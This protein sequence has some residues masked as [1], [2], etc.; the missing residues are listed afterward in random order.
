M[1][2]EHRLPIH[3]RPLSDR[4]LAASARIKEFELAIDGITAGDSVEAE[5]KEAAR[6]MGLDENEV[7]MNDLPGTL[8][9]FK[10]AVTKFY[11]LNEQGK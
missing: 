4:E 10:K 1:D 8:T 7:N 5:L 3:E 2:G 9:K 6:G 11:K